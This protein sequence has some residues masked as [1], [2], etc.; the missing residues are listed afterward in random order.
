MTIKFCNNAKDN[1]NNKDY[2]TVEPFFKMYNQK[3]FKYFNL[4]NT[5]INK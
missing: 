4:S 3:W 1:N 5:Y 2:K